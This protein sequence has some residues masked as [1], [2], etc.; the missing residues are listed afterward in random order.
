MGGWRRAT[1]AFRRATAAVS[2]LAVSAVI[3]G[4]GHG[5]SLDRLLTTGLLFGLPF[6]VVFIK[7]DW[8]HTIGTH[9]M[10]NMIPWLMAF[11]EN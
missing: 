11:P 4:L 1:R 9:Y 10:I 5:R 8:E 2:A 7:R 6:G 3:V